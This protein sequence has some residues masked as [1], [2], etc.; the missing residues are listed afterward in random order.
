[1][2]H[3][4]VMITSSY[5]RF[6]GDTVGTFLEPIAHGIAARGHAVHIVAPWHPLVRRGHREDG[7]HYHFFRY[8]PAA[9]LNVFGY[10]A[11]L[12]ADVRLRRSAWLVSPLAVTAGWCLARQVARACGAT[13]MHGHWVVP[14]GIIARLA[15]G[16]LPLIVSLHGSD[17]YV[18]ERHRLPALAARSA[19]RRAA[20]VT[21]CSRDL[22]DR[23]VGLGARADRIE[24][25]P[26]GVDT[27]RFR[28]DAGSRARARVAMGVDDRAALLLAAGRLVRKK[29][30]EYLLDATARL[31]REQ[32]RVVLALAGGGDLEGEL[33]QRAAALGV[34]DHVRFLGVVPQDRM[35]ELLAAADLAIVPSIRDDEGNVDGLPNVVMEALA[36]GTP[37]V[38]TTAGGIAEVVTDHETAVLVPERDAAALARAIEA[39]LTD[40]GRRIAIG[41][42]A[43]AM[44]QQR[45]T[46]AHTAERFEDIYNR[47][48]RP[49]EPS[50]SHAAAG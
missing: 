11:A 12:E 24:V 15:A 3:S 31:I 9:S 6:P 49:L 30:F 43:R 14:G 47:V 26:Y 27:G 20:W 44:V 8:A 32:P 21:A 17:V 46:W 42:R 13:V 37:L 23:A 39:L 48:A 28:P 1:M 16:R 19:F 36:S 4:V 50:R 10:A 18:A 7:V 2:R 33:R 22:R 40:P 29:G 41:H 45:Y 35:P 5:P 25:V 38:A 34:Q